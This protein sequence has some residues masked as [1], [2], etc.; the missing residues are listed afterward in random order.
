MADR[1]RPGHEVGE[2]LNFIAAAL[3]AELHGRMGYFPPVVRTRPV[4]GAVLRRYP[5]V[6]PQK[7]GMHRFTLDPTTAA[8]VRLRYLS[9]YAAQKVACHSEGGYDADGV[10]RPELR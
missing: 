3:V 4:A 8:P 2:A 1:L 6:S 7:S 5:E 10:A 9:V